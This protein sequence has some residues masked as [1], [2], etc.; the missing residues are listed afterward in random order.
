MFD[1]FEKTRRLG[2]ALAISFWVFVILVVPVI[3]LHT[4]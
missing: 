3:L 4:I 2:I 1:N